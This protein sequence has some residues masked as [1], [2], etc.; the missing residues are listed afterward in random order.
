MFSIL[1]CFPRSH[2]TKCKDLISPAF[3]FFYYYYFPLYKTHT[4]KKSGCNE[5]N[6]PRM[7]GSDGQW[8][9]PSRERRRAVFPTGAASTTI[10]QQAVVPFRVQIPQMEGNALGSSIL[11]FGRKK[12]W[13]LGEGRVIVWKQGHY[14]VIPVS[15]IWPTPSETPGGD[16]T[17]KRKG[18]ACESIRYLSTWA[19]KN[20]FSKE[21]M[22]YNLFRMSF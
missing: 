5:P 9:H 4:D 13:L 16:N 12:K 17:M 7:G 6:F 10:L 8:H 15:Q 21:I 1:S 18:R 11:V 20:D 19:I 3:S 22:S 2:K 14:S